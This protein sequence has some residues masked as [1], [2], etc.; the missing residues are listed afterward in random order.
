MQQCLADWLNQRHCFGSRYN[1]SRGFDKQLVFKQGP[2]SYQRIAGSGLRESNLLCRTHFSYFVYLGSL[3]SGMK[4]FHPV[5]V[6]LVVELD[7]ILFWDSVLEIHTMKLFRNDKIDHVHLY[8]KIKKRC[9]FQLKFSGF[10]LIFFFVLQYSVPIFLVVL[11]SVAT[12]R[13]QL[14]SFFK[15]SPSQSTNIEQEQSSKDTAKEQAE[16]LVSK[17]IFLL[18]IVTILLGVINNTIRPPESYDTCSTFNNKFNKFIIDLDLEIIELGGLKESSSLNTKEVDLICQLLLKKNNELFDLIDEYNKA[19]SLSPRQANIKALN[20]NDEKQKS[21]NTS[22]ASS[23][24]SDDTTGNFLAGTPNTLNESSNGTTNNSLVDIPNT[25]S[26][27]S[28]KTR[29]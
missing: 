17:I 12:S 4:A 13:E 15:E 19:R 10:L 21:K 1:F 16:I 8:L 27:L 25:S 3:D 2:Q 26:E 23:D 6:V 24:A 5:L 9:Q 20:Q 14:V 11:G 28:N 7:S 29:V 22:S 18:G